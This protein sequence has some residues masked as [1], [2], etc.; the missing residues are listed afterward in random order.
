[1]IKTPLVHIALSCERT[2]QMN[3]AS[4]FAIH[5]MKFDCYIKLIK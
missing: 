2:V 5:T 1:M 4:L 3:T